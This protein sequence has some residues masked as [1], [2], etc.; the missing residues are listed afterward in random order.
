MKDE[1]VIRCIPHLEKV[2]HENIKYLLGRQNNF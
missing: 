2:V 1:I